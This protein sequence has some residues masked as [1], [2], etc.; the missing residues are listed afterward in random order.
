LGIQ[1]NDYQELLARGGISDAY[2]GTGNAHSIAANRISY[3]LNLTGPSETIDT[4]CSSSL[5]AVNRGVQSLRLGECNAALAGGVNLMLSPSAF[6]ATSQLG[7]LSPDGRCRVFDSRAN[8]YVRGEGVGAVFLMRLSDAQK[9][10][11]PIMGVIKGVAVNH[12]GKSQSLTAPNAKAQAALVVKAHEEAGFDPSTVGYIEA[13][14]TGTEIGDPVE[15][16]GLKAGFEELARRRGASNSKSKTCGLGSV[17]SNIGHLE[18][19][20]GIVGVIKVLLAMR[21]GT[22]PEC[23]H[24]N[25]LNPFIRLNDTPFYIVDRPALWERAV[26]STG[27]E[28]PRRA[29]VSS[30]GFGGANAHIALEEGPSA[31]ERDDVECG[32]DYLFAISGRTK[33]S[34]RRRIDDLLVWLRREGSE[35]P[36]SGISRT[37][38]EGRGH[39]DYRVAVIAGGLAELT[40]ELEE[41]SLVPASFENGGNGAGPH[42]ATARS[43]SNGKAQK[44]LRHLAQPPSVL[45]GS[46]RMHLQE[47]RGIYLAGDNVD[48][49]ALYANR[50]APRRVSLPVY[51]FAKKRY[52]APV[53]PGVK[54]SSPASGNGAGSRFSSDE[55]RDIRILA[56]L[57][58]DRISLDEAEKALRRK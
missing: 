54:A 44:V 58:E 48:W 10:G 51:P 17:K 40:R 37:L 7:A 43:D 12:G 57:E 30:F 32:R 46:Y 15:I 50:E 41:L 1:F 35:H 31:G 28:V 9:A 6:V 47:L 33:E 22:I 36:L 38:N 19:A 29:G 39:Y 14:G 56:D 11:C 49:S 45:N 13:H 3:L 21:H 23:L 18:A 20:A 55:V 27:N 16:E 2:G 26:G 8:G 34:L 53:G 25:N 52:W 42:R 5:V 4:A 24:F